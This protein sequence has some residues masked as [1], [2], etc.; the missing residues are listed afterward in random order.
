M[1]MF[2]NRDMELQSLEQRCNSDRAEFIIVYGRRR[3]GKTELIKQFYKQKQHIYYLST[4]VD[5]REQMKTIVKRI[6]SLFDERVPEI[7]S[8]ED[9]FT[10]V[11]EKA[12]HKRLIFV[13]DEY[14]YLLSSNRAISSII[15]AGWDEKL[16]NS[17]IFFILCGSSISVMESELSS[18]SAL[19]GR[20][21]GQIRV[22][23][24]SFVDS[25]KFFPSYDLT[26][27]IRAY[28]ILG[29]IPMYLLEF[30]SKIDIISNIDRAIL[31]K[32]AILYEEPVFLLKEE[33]REPQTYSRIFEAISPR[34]TKLNEIATKIG[35]ESSKLPKYL[36]VLIRLNFIEKISPV[37][38][39]KAKSKQTLYIFK[40]NFFKFWYS[41][42]Y[43]NKSDLE[44]ED[45]NKVLQKIK[46]E[47]NQYV[48]FVFE[49]ICKQILRKLNLKKKLPVAFSKIG[50]WWGHIRVPGLESGVLER[51]KIEI[52]L[53]ALDGAK[54]EALFI[55]CKWS[56]LSEKEAR[57]LIQTLK[58]KAK[59]VDWQ[60]K[61]EFFG[62]FGKK[63]IGKEN[64][65]KDGFAVF[66]LDDF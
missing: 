58:Q 20:R 50:P 66:D 33:L 13:I 64:L 43:P 55:E 40:D 49:D 57:Q 27:K 32:D 10:Y 16:K 2:I 19:Y 25:I 45:R 44:G 59:S 23:P 54:K 26:D 39:T 42:V 6:A 12:Q 24:L 60:R 9:F 53:I 47:L 38:I 8:W 31:S 65:R 14:P 35:I 22:E 30:D 36:G 56:D 11:A 18:K 41:Y 28:S 61:K 17:K 5:D 15:Q 21:T 62:L 34:G 46:S 37:T 7:N 48:S 51:K 29:N 1:S 4:K 52:D 63:I 3:V